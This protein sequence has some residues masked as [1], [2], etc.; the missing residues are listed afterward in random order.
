MLYPKYLVRCDQPQIVNVGI[1]DKTEDEKI[2]WY[3]G[4]FHGHK[5]QHKT[6][7]RH[8]N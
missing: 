8:Y 2:V 4:L 5:Q 7:Y 3:N 1:Y 6:R